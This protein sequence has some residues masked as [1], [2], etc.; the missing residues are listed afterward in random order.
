MP[1]EHGTTDDMPWATMGAELLLAADIRAG[2]DADIAAWLV[3]RDDRLLV[4]LGCGAGG[5]AVALC[6]AGAAQARVRAVDGES[7]LL[8]AT[9]RRA[10]AAGCQDRLETV[11]ADLASEIPIPPGAADVIWASGVVHHLPDQ[12]ATLND[13]AG[14]LAPGGR[15]ALGE[16]GLR[17]HSLPWDLGIGEPGL[18]VRLD[19]AQDR[20]FAQMRRDLPGSVPMP[21][22]WPRALSTAGLVG[23]TSRSFLLD[24]PAPLTAREIEHGMGRLRGLLDHESLAALIQPEDR[25]SLARL[26]DSGDAVH[27]RCSGEMFLLAALTVHVGRRAA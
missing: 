15:L 24:L 21:Y 4:D 10:A 20:W 6:C 19:A 16:G 22:G 17:G 1:H 7:V 8:D 2:V 26:T 27:R 13:L 5:M 14:R 9:R 12:Q 25:R 3:D 11:R 18:E 23:V